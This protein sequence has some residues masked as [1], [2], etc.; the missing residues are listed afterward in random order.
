M[1][2]A[3]RHRA[4]TQVFR[5]VSHSQNRFSGAGE[6][7]QVAHLARQT[8]CMDLCLLACPAGW[9]AGWMAVGSH[10]AN[11]GVEGVGGKDG[12]RRGFYWF[13]MLRLP[14]T[15]FSPFC[16]GATSVVGWEKWT[17]LNPHALLRL[18]RRGLAQLPS[19]I[20]GIFA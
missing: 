13:F 3:A 1:T 5:S 6:R 4:G 16:H 12:T 18:E 11:G 15:L 8:G 14:S 19:G 7:E 20:A 2:F 9:M 17:P 10:E